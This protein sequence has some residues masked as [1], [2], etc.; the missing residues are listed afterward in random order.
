ANNP[1]PVVNGNG[2]YGNSFYDYYAYNF[3]DAANVTLDATGNWWG[4]TY[5]TSIHAKLYDSFDQATY[6]PT[7]DFTGYL[8]GLNGSPVPVVL[9]QGDL[10]S[11]AIL[12]SE[13][14]YEVQGA[15]RVLPGV[16]LTL[17]AGTILRLDGMANRLIVEGSLIV[18]GTETEPVVFTSGQEASNTGD[19]G[20]LFI[21][22]SATLVVIE[23][24]GIRYAN[25]AIEFAPS[26]L[27]ESGTCDTLCIRYSSF[28]YNNTAI[29][30]DNASPWIERNLIQYNLD[31]GIH[32]IDASPN[33]RANTIRAN[34]N[35]GVDDAGID[36][37]GASNPTITEGNQ[38]DGN[39]RYGIYIY[40]SNIQGLDPAPLITGNGLYEN[41]NFDLYS[42]NFFDASNVTLNTTGNWWGTTDPAAIAARVYDNAESGS[43][44]VADTSNFAIDPGLLGLV[45]IS[46]VTQ[47]QK[48]IHP[49]EGE[50][51]QVS[52]DLAAAQA[53]VV[54]RIR[55]ELDWSVLYESA[56]QLL[57][58]GNHTLSWDGRDN[59]GLYVKDEAYVYELY[60]SYDGRSDSVEATPGSGYIA[61]GGGTADTSFN[62]YKNDFYQGSTSYSQDVRMRVSIGYT[63]THY[64]YDGVPVEAGV[65]PIVWDGRDE[66]GEIIDGNFTIWFHDSARLATNLVIVKGTRPEISG[67]GPQIEVKSNPYR[68]TYSYE[69]ISSM[70]FSISADSYVTVTFLPLGGQSTDSSTAIRVMENQLLSARDG[71][72]NQQEHPIEW[73]GYDA[74]DTNNILM[75]TE[76]SYNFVIEATSVAT[77]FHNVYRGALQVYR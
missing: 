20:G 5:R 7:V 29:V 22:E 42:R 36:I 24:A 73:L 35:N 75:T 14:A 38:I 19:W 16:T 69:Q 6:S 26:L 48:T 30:I 51:L 25:N 23:H 40:G 27:E 50:M 62:A 21:A 11:D 44:P 34:G 46:N 3:F 57:S 39:S 43:S 9:L 65:I 77:G 49:L 52:F 55:S 76:G 56:A 66:T 15:L 31:D 63:G 4:T 28:E 45:D 17:Q 61:P 54:M 37:R 13:I 8:D 68:I 70:R 53:N 71:L 58:T 1:A 41:T 59:G 64:I 33:I 10:D 60:A 32:L 67:S 18:Q 74:S 2:I 12:T 72:G 47:N